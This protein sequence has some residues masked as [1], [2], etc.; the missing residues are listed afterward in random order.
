MSESEEQLKVNSASCTVEGE[1]GGR[2][3]RARKT[4]TSFVGHVGYISFTLP[5]FSPSRNTDYSPNTGKRK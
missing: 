4:E 5:Y 3:E 2:E 1:E